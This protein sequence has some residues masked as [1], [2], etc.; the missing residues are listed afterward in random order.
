MIAWYIE[1]LLTNLPIWFWPAIA[2]V[3]IVVYFVTTILSKL[4]QI[5]ALRYIILPVCVIVC[6]VSIFMAGGSV[7]NAE[8]K[9]RAEEM[10]AKIA[11]AQ[12]QQ[13]KTNTIIKTRIVKK[14]IVVK[15]Q[16]E[17][18]KSDI[19]RDAEIINKECKVAPE[20][21]KDLNEAAK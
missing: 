18:A 1:N 12:I 19:K 15:Q 6:L 3:S 21:I 4:P 7:L 5:R 17:Q 16:Q 13:K 2:G 9:K 20:V 8:F 11:Q 10:Q 14:Y